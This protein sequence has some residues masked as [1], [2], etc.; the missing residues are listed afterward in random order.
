MMFTES[1][2]SASSLPPKKVL[3]YFLWEILL[4]ERIIFNYSN[5]AIIVIFV[6]NNCIFLIFIVYFLNQIFFIYYE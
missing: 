2:K 5:I 4:D 6:I 3:P 1:D